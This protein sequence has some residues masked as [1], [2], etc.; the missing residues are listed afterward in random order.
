MSPTGDQ[1]PDTDLTYTVT[2]TNSGGVAAQ[3][4][5]IVDPNP[6]DAN[7]SQRVFVHLDYKLGTAAISSPWIAT[8]EFSND[9]GATW[10]Y[11]PVSGG[12]GALSGYDRT[13]T[14]IRWSIT[15][16]LATSASG[17][18]SFTSRIQ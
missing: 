6:T 11:T 14:N 10:T 15:G 13:V 16:S 2:F 3:S 7:P 12:G 8:I 1:A 17:N 18:V 9:G 5:V 4:L